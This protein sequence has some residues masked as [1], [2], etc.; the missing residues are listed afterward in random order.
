MDLLPAF[1]EG[2]NSIEDIIQPG[3]LIQVGVME[4]AMGGVV[5]NI[6]GALSRLGLSVCPMGKMGD[7]LLGQSILAKMDAAGLPTN[8]MIKDETS[9]TSYTIVLNIPGIDRIPLHFP[10]ANQPKPA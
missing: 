1:L 6:A 5:P 10:G 8:G 7:D 2:G 4:Q 9:G 3:K